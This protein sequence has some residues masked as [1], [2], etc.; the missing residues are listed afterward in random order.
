MRTGEKLVLIVVVAFFVI[1]AYL[2]PQMPSQMASHWNAGDEV[3]GYM[4]KLWG[5]F[6][7]PLAGFGL[8]LL[9][10]TIPKID[11]LRR[12]IE[13][14]RGH[15]DAFVVVIIMFLFYIHS[16]TILWS[17]GWRFSMLQMMIPALAVLFYYAGILIQNARRN[18]FIG[19]R[20]PWTLS[21]ERVWNKTHERGAKMFKAAAVIMLPGMVFPDCALYFIL[22]P[23]LSLV[24]YLFAYSYF[25]YEK[26]H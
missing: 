23:I 11:P 7:M 22:V 6:L 25:E 21:S 12:N 5:L 24:I 14:F 9:F 18:W 1:G 26:R 19:I 10:F 15:Y 4:P 8:F 3:D 17:I 13:K 2:Y 16:L 20:T